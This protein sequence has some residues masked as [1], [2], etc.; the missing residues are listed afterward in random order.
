MLQSFEFANTNKWYNNI[1]FFISNKKLKMLWFYLFLVLLLCFSCLTITKIQ[2]DI[3]YTHLCLN[4]LDCIARYTVGKGQ[5]YFKYPR[6]HLHGYTC[7]ILLAK[8]MHDINNKVL[9]NV[10]YHFFYI[11]YAH[12]WTAMGKLLEY[13][14][15]G[16]FKMIKQYNI[17]Y[18][19]I[20]V[21]YM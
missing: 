13:L 19:F 21:K 1:I 9:R 14:A 15:I 17:P 7:I 4:D 16:S 20:K 11:E 6:A 10:H 8:I 3:S 12:I 2:M 5:F 18:S